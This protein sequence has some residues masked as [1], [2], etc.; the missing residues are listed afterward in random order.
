[1]ACKGQALQACVCLKEKGRDP[2]KVPKSKAASSSQRRKQLGSDLHSTSLTGRPPVLAR[3]IPCPCS[4]T[5]RS[6]M[7][8][9]L[10]LKN[11]M[12]QCEC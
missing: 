8:T 5:V 2:R 1:M 10:K 7:Q 11:R 4:N 9:N 6:S 12:R 3:S